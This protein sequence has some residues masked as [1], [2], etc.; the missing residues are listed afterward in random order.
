MTLTFTPDGTVEGL[1]SEE[2]DLRELGLMSVCRAT[3]IRFNE[4]H[5][6]WR[7]YTP[8]G[9]LLYADRSRNACLEWEKHNLQAY[10]ERNRQ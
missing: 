9:T 7:V 10:H 3:V 8:D 6:D 1:Y 4:Y 2:L 5:Q